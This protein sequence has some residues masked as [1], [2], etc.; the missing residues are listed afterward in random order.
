VILDEKCPPLT[1]SCISLALWEFL[2]PQGDASKLGFDLDNII[3][4]VPK[5]SVKLSRLVFSFVFGYIELE[6]SQ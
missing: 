6:I 5:K 1:R 3:C 2:S 4:L